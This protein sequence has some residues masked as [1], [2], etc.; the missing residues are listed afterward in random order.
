MFYA[1]LR[2][3]TYSKNACNASNARELMKQNLKQIQS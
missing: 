2:V 3:K 1:L